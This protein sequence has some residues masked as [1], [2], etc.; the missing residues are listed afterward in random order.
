MS[1]RILALLTNHLSSVII[2]ITTPYFCFYSGSV[3][4]GKVKEAI[5]SDSGEKPQLITD[6]CTAMD[7]QVFST[8]SNLIDKVLHGEPC[9]DSYALTYTDPLAIKF[10]PLSREITSRAMC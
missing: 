7:T 8:R 1:T 10:D 3:L 9:I 5:A 2:A 6:Y 4:I